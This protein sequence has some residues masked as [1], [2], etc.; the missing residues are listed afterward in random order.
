MSVLEAVGDYL[1]AQGQGTQG[2]SLFL[3]RMPDQPDVCVCVY[4]YEG[5]APLDTMGGG[6]F[7]VDR[8]RVQVLVRAARDDYPT[9]R[10][11]ALTIRSLLGAVAGQTLSGVS[12]LRLRPLGGVN[13]L[14][15]DEKDR[16]LFSVNFEAV[17]LP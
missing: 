7:A 12:V 14:G 6:A 17:V 10:D 9:G 11:K 5:A 8:P 15:P 4:E 16:P 1:A 3:G 2:T 13:P